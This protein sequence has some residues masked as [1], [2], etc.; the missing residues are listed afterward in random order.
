MTQQGVD[1]NSYDG[2]INTA[3]LLAIATTSTLG[4]V[5]IDNGTN[6]EKYKLASNTSHTPYPTITVDSNG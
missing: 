4:G 2:S 3:I 1:V 6:S 5:I